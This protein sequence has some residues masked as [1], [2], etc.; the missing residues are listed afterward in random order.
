MPELPQRPDGRLQV[1]DALRGFALAALFLVHMLESYELYWA[2]PQPSRAAGLVFLF[3]MG[4]AFSLLALCFGFSFY[5]MM[6]NAVRR[7][8]AFSA[9]FAWRMLVLTAIGFVHSLVYRGDI[10]EILAGLGLLLLAA[11]YVRSNRLLLAVA[12]LFFLQPAL[13]W[14]ILSATGDAA[15]TNRVLNDVEDPGLSVYLHGDFVAVLRVNLWEGQLSKWRFMFES[16]RV[17]Q[18]VGLFLV[19][20]V[21]GRIGFFSRLVEFSRTRH[22]L[23]AV[24]T[25]AVIL[26]HQ[27][28]DSLTTWFA[29][30]STTAA[31]KDAFGTI[32]DS[33]FNLAGTAVWALLIVA[34]WQGPGRV[35]MLPLVPLGRATLTLYITQS[36]L[37]VPFFYAFG[38]GMHAVLSPPL[39][40]MVGL[41]AIA[42]Q[43]WTAKSWFAHFT[44]GPLEWVW[45]ALTYGRFDIPFR[46]RN[47]SPADNTQVPP[48]NSAPN[49]RARPALGL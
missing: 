20:M 23:L 43:F 48:G 40:L 38:L 41:A 5:V 49:E 36:I 25:A 19:G 16:G 14:K 17:S 47:Q 15:M 13:W 1:V 18:I 29:G 34:I 39:R 42:V 27:G 26:L 22:T 9:R 21:L 12:F 33:W 32:C 45:R 31:A 44:Y 35:V 30:L 8:A 11:R 4:K 3:F 24:A 2:D 28:N 46:R 37:F 6:N 10:I 7:G